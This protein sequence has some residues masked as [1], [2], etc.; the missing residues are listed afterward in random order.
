MDK[1]HSRYP[2]NVCLLLPSLLGFLVAQT[3][4]HLPATQETQVRSLG[5]ED[6]LEKETATHSSIL[7]REIPWTEETGRLQSMGLQ[8]VGHY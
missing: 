3:V 1:V 7:A 4:K 6:P 5:L 2:I 8:R